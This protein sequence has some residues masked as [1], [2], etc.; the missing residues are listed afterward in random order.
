MRVHAL[1]AT[2]AAAAL[3]PGF[4]LAQQTCEQ[5][6]DNQIAGT[7]VGAGLGALV[8]SAVAGHGDKTTGAVIGGVGGAIIGNQVARGSKDCAH[9]YG[10]YD[11]NGM[12]HATSVSRA[13]ARGYYDRGGTWVDGAPNG[14]YDR[15]G[16]WTTASTSADAGGYYD[17]GGRWIPASA[18]GYYDSD[19]RLVAGV[20]SGHYDTRGRWI[21]GSTTGAYDSAGRWMDGAQTGHRDASGVWVADAQPGYYNQNGRWVAGSVEGYYDSRGRWV[22]TTRDASASSPAY[23]TRGGA[24]AD[25]SDFRS[26]VA[27]LD[28]RIRHRL[29]RG[30][31]T[32]VEGDRALRTLAVIRRQEQNMYHRRGQ[33]NDRDEAIIQA[34]LDS[35][36]AS[37]GGR[38]DDHRYD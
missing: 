34:R 1:A 20:A 31:L 25:R 37:I 33:L 8:G 32:R 26:R 19:G 24:S 22:G 36:D 23:D 21:A 3:I 14:Y 16:R 2:L 35:L 10:Y 12:W 38:R 13:E 6:R 15:A 7:V 27:Q 18:T 4:A 28:R 29:D 30:D 9:A 17:A 11:N 5:R